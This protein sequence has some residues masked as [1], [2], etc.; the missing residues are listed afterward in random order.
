MQSKLK[1]W[2][3][4]WRPEFGASF[5]SVDTAAWHEWL[6]GATGP[7]IVMLSAGL[8][9]NEHMALI[10]HT[11]TVIFEGQRVDSESPSPAQHAEKQALPVKET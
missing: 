3:N 11:G 1:A 6:T 7:Y 9:L 5:P 10:F 2:T 8:P 4:G